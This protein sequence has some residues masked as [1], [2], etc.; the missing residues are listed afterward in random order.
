MRS[1]YTRLM[2]KLY[3]LCV[4]IAI[5]SVIIMTLLVG[6]GVYLRYV[7]G[8][9]AFAEPVSIFLAIQLSF[10]GAAACYRANAHLSLDMFVKY[11]PGP[12]RRA[13]RW[14]VHVLMAGVCV[15][16][17]YYGFYLVETTIGQYYPEFQYIPIMR[18]VTV[19]IAYTAIP[20]SGL[21]TLLF[22]IEKAFCDDLESNAVTMTDGE[23]A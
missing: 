3:W 21:I 2:D 13:I 20:L 16:M 11:L 8:M 19:G 6:I 4:G 22:V 10:Y 5:V 14:L 12:P 9:G 23:V 18:Q 7:L 15:A 17:A 1:I